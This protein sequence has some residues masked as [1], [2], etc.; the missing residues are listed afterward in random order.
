MKPSTGSYRQKLSD[1]SFS[2]FSLNTTHAN[3][4]QNIIEKNN[5]LHP[6]SS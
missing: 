6:G 3:N 4:S 1:R 2:V 5:E